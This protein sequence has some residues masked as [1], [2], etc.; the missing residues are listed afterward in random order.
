MIHLYKNLEK[1]KLI[2]S[3][4]KQLSGCLRLGVRGMSEK[5]H[6]GTFWGDENVLI[7][8][9]VAATW[10]STSVKILKMFAFYYI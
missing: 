5:G 2:Y 7:L 10:M 4:R 3:N 9:L 6:K 1:A 8:I